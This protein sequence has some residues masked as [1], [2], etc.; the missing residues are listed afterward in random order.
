MCAVHLLP[1]SSKIYQRLQGEY[2]EAYDLLDSFADRSTQHFQRHAV[3][4]FLR[5]AQVTEVST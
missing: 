2:Q 4:G 1:N 5:H 3:C